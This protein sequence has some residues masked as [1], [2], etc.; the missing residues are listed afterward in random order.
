MSK[1]RS[2]SNPPLPQ[3]TPPLLGGWKL[4]MSR[5]LTLLTTVWLTLAT[6]LVYKHP[7]LIAVF[8]GFVTCF[9]LAGS[10]MLFKLVATHRISSLLGMATTALALSFLMTTTNSSTTFLSLAM[11]T[12]YL[13][14]DH[15]WV[16]FIRQAKPL[17]LVVEDAITLT[18]FIVTLATQPVEDYRT[19]I[20]LWLLYKTVRLIYQLATQS[21]HSINSKLAMGKNLLSDAAMAQVRPPQNYWIIHGQSY[22][23]TLFLDR[24]PGGKE[25]LMLGQ[26]RDC[27][28][29]FESYHPFTYAHKQILQ[30]YQVTI[31]GKQLTVRPRQR[32][33]A[34]YALLCQRV[35]QQLLEHDIDP[36]TDRAAT[37]GRGLYYGIILV[38]LVAT[39][40]AHIKVCVLVGFCTPCHP[41]LAH[42]LSNTLASKHHSCREVLWGASSL[43]FSV[44]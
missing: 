4:H 15:W 1:T 11:A 5:T 37:P 22:D 9:A 36:T 10:W 8:A 19:S 39:G 14:Y 41:R 33:D 17:T 21:K 31:P 6:T 34:F 30:K 2:N 32:H 29:L 24:H 12:G 23:L 40:R 3:T 7:D 16:G 44:G 27:T 25:A 13:A 43:P 20:E 26:G 38:A 28:A 42:S 18:V 35:K